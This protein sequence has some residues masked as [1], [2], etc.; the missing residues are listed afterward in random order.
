M[1]IKFLDAGCGDA[2]HI[3]FL[4]KD[5]GYHNILIDGGVEQG[6]V[7]VQGIREEI[8]QIISRNEIID[9]WIITH[10]DND[11]VGGILRFIKDTPVVSQI[12]LKK[13]I[14]WYN[15]SDKDF[16]V[17]IKDSNLKSVRQ[18]ITLREYLLEK[19]F[20]N[21]FITDKLGTIEFYGISLTI[22]SPSAEKLEKLVDKWRKSEI[23]IVKAESSSKKAGKI[24]DYN[25]PIEEFDFDDY[26]EDASV[27][28]GSSIAFLL[29]YGNDNILFLSDSHPSTVV[30]ALL[31]L[32]YNE[33]NKITAKY[34]QIAH[35]GSKFNTSDQLLQLIDCGNFVISADGYNKHCLPNKKTL[36]RVIKNRLPSKVI[37]FI[38]Q[39]NNLTSTIFNVDKNTNV[40]LI[41]PKKGSNSLEFNIP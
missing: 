6:D 27:E 15:Y 35:H 28:N 16:E 41:F 39:K 37:F 11:H 21:E 17:G 10:I 1:T 23:Q 5:G 24:T 19:S 36:A 22:L 2:I 3:R 4:G 30:S 25:I 31:K 12:D 20:V 26:E 13:T 14:F 9:L 33:R 7:Y 32:G 29:R 34:T 18:G 40:S 8:V 38:T